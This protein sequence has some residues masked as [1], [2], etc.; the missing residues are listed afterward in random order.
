MTQS[1]SLLNAH[2]PNHKLTIRTHQTLNNQERE[3]KITLTA[4][5]IQESEAW[6]GKNE[7]EKKKSTNNRELNSL[8]SSLP[9]SLRFKYILVVGW[10]FY[11]YFFCYCCCFFH[12]IRFQF[13]PLRLLTLFFFLVVLLHIFVYW[14]VVFYWSRGSFLDQ[15]FRLFA[16]YFRLIARFVWLVVNCGSAVFVYRFLSRLFF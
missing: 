10:F 16:V 7:R 14:L 6:I 1:S 4:D 5:H 11:F 2:A 3:K 12:S 8:S 15:L 13:S 9:F